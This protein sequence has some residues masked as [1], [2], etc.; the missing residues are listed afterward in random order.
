[1]NMRNR[2]EEEVARN[3]RYL[4]EDLEVIK[5]REQRLEAERQLLILKLIAAR[6]QLLSLREQDE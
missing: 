3:M 4:K 1:M 5:V 2:P 6:E